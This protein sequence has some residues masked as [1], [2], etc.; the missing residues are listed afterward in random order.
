M[1]RK[2]M[3][4]DLPRPELGLL[5]VAPTGSV[6][7]PFLPWWIGVQDVP[8]EFGQHRYLTENSGPTFINPDFQLQEATE[9]AGRLFKRLMYYTCA[10]PQDH[11]ARV[12]STLEAFET[13]LR[14]R[15][16]TIERVAALAYDEDP[17]LGRDLLTSF[18]HDQAA[19]AMEMGRG[20]LAGIETEVSVRHGISRPPWGADINAGGVSVNCL[21][22]AD[23]DRR[24]DD[25]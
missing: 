9:F 10:F 19:N 17:A 25:Q 1:S 2:P 11:L 7:A 18:T 15:T 5:W 22:G 16:A 24:R 21:A 23:P 13:D 14:E 4:R 20:L 6:T 3:R 8:P 12:Q